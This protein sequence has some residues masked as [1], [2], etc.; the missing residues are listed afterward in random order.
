MSEKKYLYRI[1]EEET[2]SKKKKNYENKR[3]IKNSFNLI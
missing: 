2:K 1:E 3:T